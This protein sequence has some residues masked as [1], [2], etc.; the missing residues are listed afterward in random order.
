MAAVTIG[1]KLGPY[2]I[3]Q[4]IGAGGMGE[5]YEAV[6][7]RLHRTVAIK[8][9][10]ESMA[11]DADRR[12]RFEREARAVGSVNHPHICT[13]HDVGERDGTHYLVME[14]IEGQTLERRLARGRL[15]MEQ[16]LRYA[17][18]II[19]ALEKAHEQGVVHRDLQ[20]ANIMITASGVKLLDFGLVKLQAG[21]HGG[22]G[23]V[24]APASAA[25]NLTVA[26]AILGT[27]QYMAPEQLQGEEADA[28]TD[29][30]AVGVVLYEMIT[31]GGRSKGRRRP[32]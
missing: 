13:L 3:R 24:Q 20:P 29:L 21:E 32:A 7:T 16:A 9:L 17:V 27:P 30:F 4:Q 15:P 22:L 18:Q 10:P 5:V 8:V 12:Q 19:D 25:A 2:E 28:R 11:A 23:G 31:G 6:D 14:R 1:T 26:G